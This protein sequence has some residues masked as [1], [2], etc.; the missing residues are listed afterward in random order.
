MECLHAPPYRCRVYFLG[1]HGI[2]VGLSQHARFAAYLHPRA[3]AEPHAIAD[4]LQHHLRAGRG[5][6]GT[7]LHILYHQRWRSGPAS[8]VEG[9]C[10]VISYRVQVTGRLAGVDLKGRTYLDQIDDVLVKGHTK[11]TGNQQ[12]RISWH[13][14]STFFANWGLWRL[15]ALFV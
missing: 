11:I 13:F 9:I 12:L 10:S 8:C 2:T 5:T 15:L 6:R 1:F 14:F 4:W 3:Q 7:G